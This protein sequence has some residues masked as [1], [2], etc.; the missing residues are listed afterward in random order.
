MPGD[1]RVTTELRLRTPISQG[2]IKHS[3]CTG[4]YTWLCTSVYEFVSPFLHLYTVSQ[5]H[6]HVL[7]NLC[8]NYFLPVEVKLTFSRSWVQRSRSGNDG[9]GIW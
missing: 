2:G 4:G 1:A 7:I 6:G 9:H 5:N 8:H 3:A